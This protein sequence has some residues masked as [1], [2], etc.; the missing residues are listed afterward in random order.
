MA[1]NLE[2]PPLWFWIVAVLVTAWGAMGVFGFY[3]DIAMSDA[4]RAQ[5]SDYDRRLLASRPAWYPF[6]YGGAVWSGLFGGIA[7][8]LRS[9]H[10]PSLLVLSAV[11]VVIMFGYIFAATDLIRVKGF[12]AAAGFPIVI[13]VIALA[14]IWFAGVARKRRWIG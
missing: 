1:S 13:F 3:A 2:K 11:L 8:L 4:T 5:L 14:Q 10:A 9:A 7:L 12:F 6:A